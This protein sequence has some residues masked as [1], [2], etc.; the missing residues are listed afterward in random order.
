M[1]PYSWLEEAAERIAPYIQTTPLT[2]DPN[3]DIYLK[4]ENHQRTGSFKLRGALNK[5]LTL[6]DWE[7][8]RGLVAASAGNHGQGLALAGSLVGAPVTIFAS[9]H[10]APN[11]VQAM[12][13]LGADV[14][15]VPGGYGE[16]EA[17]G[18][19][20]A[21]QS[22]LTWVSPYN[23]GQVI[24]GQGTLGLELLNE[25]PRLPASTWVVPVGGGGLISGIGAAVY[26]GATILESSGVRPRPVEN[27]RLVGVQS[28]ASPFAHAHFHRGTDSGVEELPSLADGLAGPIET[29]SVTIPLMRRCL[30]DFVLVSEEHIRQAVVH[31]WQRYQEVLEGSAAAALA[32]VLSGVITDR[33]AVVVLSGG[34]IKPDTLQALVQDAG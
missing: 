24:A 16:A 26:A 34:N 20:F 21:A 10:A 31:S 14:R 30:H 2:Y 29:S 8:E 11:K 33:P 9:E 22:G 15:L 19:A 32:A 7:R 4:W 27:I 28:D 3:N 12:R 25:L 5:V 18:L 13:D 1:I 17:A 6:Q 23:D